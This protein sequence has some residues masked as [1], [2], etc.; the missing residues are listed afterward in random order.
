MA[1][2]RASGVDWTHYSGNAWIGCTEAGPGCSACYAR[3][4]MADRLHLVEWGAGK[5]RKKVKG[6]VQK[7]RKANREALKAGERRRFFINPHADLFDNEVPDGWR[8]EVFD[9]MKTAGT[10]DFI[11][12]TKRIGNAARMLPDD[13]GYGYTNAW[14]MATMVNQQEVDRDMPKLERIP[15]IVKGLSIEPILGEIDLS[16]YLHILDWVIIG[17]QSAQIGGEAPV[18]AE[19]RWV[20]KLI[21]QCLAAG[22]AVYFKQ[23]GTG[24]G[25][26]RGGHLIDGAEIRQFPLKNS[27]RCLGCG[28]HDLHACLTDRGGCHWATRN[29]CSSCTSKS[30]EAA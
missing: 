29:L 2:V 16:A 27:R 9:I 11:L 19:H 18:K 23:W 3:A 5:P 7:V 15:V 28:C 20:R 17:G 13:W 14:L 22:I 26:I 12:V 6:F 4:M 8:H 10:L 21:D 1:E 25:G 24:D 30:G